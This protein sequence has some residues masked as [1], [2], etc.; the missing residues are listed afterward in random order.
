MMTATYDNGLLD[1]LPRTQGALIPNAPL[2]KFTWFRVGGPAEVLFEPRDEEDLLAFL[3][4]K[5]AEVPVTIIGT[6]SNLLVR[7]G[8]VPGVVIRLGKSFADIRVSGQRITAGSGAMDVTVARAARD[9][10]LAGF[11]FLIGIPGTLGGAC[12]MNAGAYG[13]EIKDIFIAARAVTD[14]GELLDL[15]PAGMGFSYRHT[16]LAEGTILLEATLEGTLGETD[17]IAKRMTAIQAARGDTQPVKSRTGGSTFA[18]PD[19]GRAW[20]LVDAAGCRGLIRGGAQVSPQH[21]NFLINTGNATAADLEGLG[22]EV[23]RRVMETSGI[24]L[25]WEIRRIGMPLQG[26]IQEVTS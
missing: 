9:N 25:R 14:Q 8:G 24:D 5:P 17:A 13:A 11:E 10:G 4:Q 19:G 22:E 26:S 3:A 20:E 16:D 18:N 2:A 12:F 23:R 15:T 6:A 1:R 7:D 21:C